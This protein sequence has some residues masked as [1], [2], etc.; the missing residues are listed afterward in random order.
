MATEDGGVAAV[1]YAPCRVSSPVCDLVVETEYPFD[2]VVR[3]RVLRSEG[4]WPM[5][6]RI[7][8]WAS[9]AVVLLNGSRLEDP[10]AGSFYRVTRTWSEGDVVEL[11]LPLDVRFQGGHQGLVSVF[12]GPLMYCLRIGESWSQIKGEAPLIDWAIAPTTPWNYGLALHASSYAVSSYGIPEAPWDN[13][14][15]A[16]VLKAKGKRLP[17][18]GLVDNS[19]GDIDGCPKASDEPLEDIELVPYGSTRLRMGA[20]PIL[21]ETGAEWRPIVDA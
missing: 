9:G 1:A 3:V 7:P 16:V 19:A 13:A 2:G 15:P 21:D 11:V 20:F 10:V 8:S 18:W 17:S 4:A 14:A 12:R 5:L 6:L